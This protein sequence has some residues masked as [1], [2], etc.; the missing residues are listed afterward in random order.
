MVNQTP[1]IGFRNKNGKLHTQL[2]AH[3]KRHQ[4]NIFPPN[5]VA[6]LIAIT[7]SRAPTLRCSACLAVAVAHGREQQ[8]EQ[9]P[10]RQV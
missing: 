5:A 7:L 9:E 4:P 8:E 3:I 1:V 6:Q 10:A 2:I